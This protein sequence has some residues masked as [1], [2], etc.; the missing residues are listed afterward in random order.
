[1]TDDDLLTEFRSDVPPPDHASAK[2]AYEHAIGGRRRLPRR[3]LGYALA[4]VVVAGGLA[5]G[6]SATLGGASSNVNP[7]RQQIVDRAMRQVQQA[8]GGDRILKATLDGSLLTIDGKTDEPVNGVVEPFEELVLAHVADDQLRAAG[9]QGVETI[10]GK[11]FGEASLAPLSSIPQLSADACD[12]PA[13]TR[14]TSV[15][16]ASGR[17]IPL[18]RGFCVI[19]LTTSDPKAFAGYIQETLNQLFAAVP[20]AKG[21]RGRGVVIE[22]DDGNGVPVIVIA[23]GPSTDQGGAVYVRPSLEC[24]TSIVSPPVGRCGSGPGNG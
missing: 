1:M 4:A 22:A 8:F 10:K 2:R 19:H 23:W 17:E 24:K 3:R 16:T 13:G 9:Y 14:L 12:I 15:T 7:E 5:G 6:L 20:A 21:S 18:L 11:G